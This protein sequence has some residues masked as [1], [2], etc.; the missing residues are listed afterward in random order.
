MS[1]SIALIKFPLGKIILDPF[2]TPAG[3]RPW[4]CYVGKQL[5]IHGTKQLTAKS[6]RMRSSY[7]PQYRHIS[8]FP[9]ENLSSNF[10]VNPLLKAKGIP[11]LATIVRRRICELT[12]CS[13][14]I[15]SRKNLFGILYPGCGIRTWYFS[16]AR[17]DVVV[18]PREYSNGLSLTMA[19]IHPSVP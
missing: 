12:H 11:P 19:F 13:N 14:Q 8:P 4:Y 3:D 9:V 6:H 17:Q 18:R 10:P 7:T 2:N 1:S 5:A 16:V 15:S